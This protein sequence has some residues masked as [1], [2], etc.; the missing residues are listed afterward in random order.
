MENLGTSQF[1]SI[2]MQAI[3]FHEYGGPG[4]LVVDQVPVSHPQD[5]QVLVR[6]VAVGVNPADW[7]MRAG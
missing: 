1:G 4:V 2:T 7:R 6:V 5:N 3:R